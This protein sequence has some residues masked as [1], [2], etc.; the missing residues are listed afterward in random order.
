MFC[1]SSVCYSVLEAL[2]VIL[3]LELCLSI[4][5]NCKANDAFQNM[6]IWRCL[7]D[8]YDIV[9]VSIDGVALQYNVMVTLTSTHMVTVVVYSIYTEYFM[10]GVSFCNALLHSYLMAAACLAVVRLCRQN[11]PVQQGLFLLPCLNNICMQ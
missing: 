5:V 3:L 10:F 6:I 4:G 1:W 8:C 9:V 2:F 11:V 7:T